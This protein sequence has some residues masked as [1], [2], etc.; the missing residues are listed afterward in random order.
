M[1]ACLHAPKLSPEPF[2]I[3][4]DLVVP[5]AKHF[6]ALA[7]QISVP[8]LV[9]KAPGVLGTVSFDDQLGANAKKVDDVG[10]DRNL[11]PKLD[12]IQATVAQKTPEPQFAVGRRST[13]R[14]GAGALVRR[15]A[16][17]SLHRSSIGGATLIRRAFDPPPSPRGRRGSCTAVRPSPVPPGEA[18][19]STSSPSGR[20]WPEGP[21]EGL[22][23]AKIVSRTPSR[24]CNT[25]LFQNR[26]SFQPRLS[27]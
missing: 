24:F 26:R 10:A 11:S 17:V 2:A 14:S 20:W 12:A 25:S 23:G 22:A 13:H 3:L 18:G 7:F 21:D 6:P 4:Q 5:E 1:R 9:G 16:C 19:F 27:R 8:S 15:D